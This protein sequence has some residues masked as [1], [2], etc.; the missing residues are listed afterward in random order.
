[1]M[2]C[3]PGQVISQKQEEIYHCDGRTHTYENILQKT[4][5]ESKPRDLYHRRQI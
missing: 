1:M 2:T 5:L 3:L 4:D